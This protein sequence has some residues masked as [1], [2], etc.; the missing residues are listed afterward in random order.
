MEFDYKKM[1]IAYLRH[2]AN[3]E[4]ISYVTNYEYA[5]KEL[6]LTDDEIKELEKL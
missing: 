2:I 5:L 1:L 4:G 6:G 3:M